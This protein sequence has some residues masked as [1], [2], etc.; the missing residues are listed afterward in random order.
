MTDMMW[1]MRLMIHQTW[2]VL[3]A[4]PQ[5]AWNKRNSPWSN[6]PKWLSGPTLVPSTS[7]RKYRWLGFWR[8][9]NSPLS[10]D[11]TVWNSFG[12]D[13]CTG[14]W[15]LQMVWWLSSHGRQR[16]ILITPNG[17][18]N[19]GLRGT[20]QNMLPRFGRRGR[21][22]DE[23]TSDLRWIRQSVR[24]KK[25]ELSSQSSERQLSSLWFV[26]CR[27]ATMTR[28]PAINCTLSAQM[29]GTGRSWL[30][31]WN[32]IVAW[33]I[34]TVWLQYTMQRDAGRIGQRVYGIIRTRANDEWPSIWSDYIQQ[35]PF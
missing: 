34:H 15:Q 5:S 28:H 25:R 17:F 24:T 33:E 6:L 1:I 23:A 32:K 21:G 11:R 13:T 14:R 16:I 19:S 4:K 31:S 26:E 12:I 20:W 18:G 7:G 9:C 27:T 29:W 3:K 22:E 30:I 2:V 8:K 10:G 35:F